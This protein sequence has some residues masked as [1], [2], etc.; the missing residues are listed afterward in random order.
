[1][2]ISSNVYISTDYAGFSNYEAANMLAERA[3]LDW[4]RAYN[5]LWALPFL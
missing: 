2:D 3:A 1:M 5:N 4:F